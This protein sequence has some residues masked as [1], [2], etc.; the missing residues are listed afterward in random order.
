MPGK[1]VVLIVS[2]EY[3]PYTSWGGVA[4]CSANLAKLLNREGYD[5]EILAESDG[6]DEFIHEDEQGNLVHRLCGGRSYG[7]KLLRA[8][9]GPLGRRVAY[10]D[11]SFAARVAE[12]VFELTTLWGRE[13][14]W[15]EATSWRAQ[16]ALLQLVPALAAQ[17]IVRNVTPLAE[18]VRANQGSAPSFEL[19]VALGLEMLQ[20]LLTR[21]RFFSSTEQHAPESAQGNVFLLPFD[22]SRVE[23]RRSVPARQATFRLLMVG[24]L[25]PRKGF[26]NVCA[27]LEQLEPEQ[28]AGLRIVA[29]GRDTAYG[30]HGSY[31]KLLLERFAAAAG[32]LEF[33]GHITDGE[34]RRLLAEADVGLVASTS[35][36]FGYNLVELLAAGLPVIT[37]D[38]GAASELERRGVRYLGKYRDL[39]GL[40]EI[41]GGL[42]ARLAQYQRSAPDNRGRLEAV[43]RK[44]D[45]AYLDY[46][47][48]NVARDGLRYAEALP[49]LL[50]SN[51]I[52]ESVDVIVPSYNR[53]GELTRSLD[54]ILEEVE[55]VRRKGISCAVTIVHQNEDLPERLYAWR[56]ELRDSPS[57]QLVFSSPPSLTRARNAGLRHTSRD[58]V[59]FVDDDVALTPGFITAH[60]AAASAHPGAVGTA[61]RVRSRLD[62][63]DTTDD[64][65]VGQIR[66]S[67]FIDCNYN[68][69]ANGAPLVPMTATGANMGYRRQPMNALLGECWF[70]ERFQG[71]AFREES[72][73]GMELFRRGAH[74]V[75][76]PDAFLY[77][78]AAEEGGC[79]SRSRQRTLRA[80]IRHE[81]YEYL[82]LN[83]LYRG[84]S[85]LRLLA[86]GL[87]LRRD[88]ASFEHLRTLA[89]KLVIHLGAYRAGRRLAAP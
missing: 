56:P 35:E 80:R 78:H 13:I 44:N 21:H 36:S 42:P 72:M 25:E 82:F 55:R 62:Q 1:R 65:A 16:S 52:L 84:R 2:D 76:A 75:Y 4:Q 24:R 70:D 89:A 73:L 66:A 49:Q 17:T 11:L 3:P 29:V 39:A 67:G 30:P 9:T 18:V 48:E 45:A 38:V 63:F 77:H 46:V 7:F 71:S 51:G 57:L 10:R 64:R 40:R 50:R 12:R 41:L 5:A 27:A 87:T 81:G 22:F 34:L 60:L 74:L 15:V 32:C 69:V 47:R 14:L 31:Q 19:R 68:S 79:E 86:P 26:E 61:G 59:I 33:R 20:Q 23:G 58:F 43:Y 85:W 37:S 88:A 83:E 8:L 6:Q 53:F 28:R 54:S